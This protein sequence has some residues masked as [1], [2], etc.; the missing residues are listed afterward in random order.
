MVV[1]ISSNESLLIRKEFVKY[2]CV[3]KYQ[4]AIRD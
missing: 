3:R 1:L 2:R 4:E